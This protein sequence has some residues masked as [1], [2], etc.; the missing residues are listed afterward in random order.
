MCQQFRVT[1]INISSLQAPDKSVC[2]H[3][4]RLT[5]FMNKKEKKA[6]GVVCERLFSVN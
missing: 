2:M 6:V 3:A 5:T 4:L 1:E